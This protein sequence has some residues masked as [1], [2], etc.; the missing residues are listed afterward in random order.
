MF[1]AGGLQRGHRGR[2]SAGSLP[3]T[4]TNLNQVSSH[5]KS[6]SCSVVPMTNGTS[7]CSLFCAHTSKGGA[8]RTYP[9]TTATGPTKRPL[10]GRSSRSS[11]PQDG[12]SCHGMAWKTEPEG[13][14]CSSLTFTASLCVGSSGEGNL[15]LRSVKRNAAPISV[16]HFNQL[17]TET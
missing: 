12:Y 2:G 10:T 13:L 15:C 6:T 17:R 8:S 7:L 5:L 11:A 1:S 3:T 14:I 4:S 9:S 16:L